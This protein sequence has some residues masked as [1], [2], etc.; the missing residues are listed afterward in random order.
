[1][2]WKVTGAAVIVNLAILTLNAPTST[3]QNSDALAAAVPAPAAPKPAATPSSL[4][5]GHALFVVRIAE[6]SGAPFKEQAVVQLWLDDAEPVY[7]VTRGSSA[8]FDVLQSHRYTVRASV[9]GYEAAE[10]T[11]QTFPNDTY[12]QTVLRPMPES[13]PQKATAEARALSW[14]PVKID[15]E[16][17]ELANGI[18]CPTATALDGAMRRV[19]E[20]TKNV[21]RI[22]ATEEVVHEALAPSGKIVSTEHRKFDYVVTISTVR[23]GD[24][25]VDEWRNGK[26]DYRGFPQNIATLGLPSLAFVFHEHYRA[27]FDFTC[28]GLGQWQGRPTWLVG[29]RQR[30]DRPSEI[31]GYDV[32]GTLYPVSLD[33]RAWIAADSFQIVRMEADL[34]K[35]MPKIKLRDEH[36]AIEY[37]PVHFQQTGV[38]MWLPSRADLYFDFR[39]HKYHRV[40][41]FNSYL[42]F[43]VSASEKIDAPKEVASRGDQ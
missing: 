37:R 28:Q 11:L 12:Y 6:Q 33:G 4:S 26:D 19:D 10:D 2:N 41:S 22:A 35:A 34:M 30:A 16:K 20:L 13:R 27:D 32:E 24:L 21:N 15:R 42:L 8:T 17:L 1:M 40:H 31:R 36:Q 3:A 25:D 23:S 7:A 39:Q 5:P 43:S 29:F 9:A 18:V 38:D 14:R